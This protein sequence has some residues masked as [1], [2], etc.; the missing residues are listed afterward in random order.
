MKL[1]RQL[2][3]TNHFLQKKQ[4]KSSSNTSTADVHMNF[5]KIESMSAIQENEQVS[6]KKRDDD[7]Y[8]ELAHVE[9]NVRQIENKQSESKEW[10]LRFI[11]I[12]MTVLMVAVVILTI[13]RM[14]NDGFA[15]KFQQKKNE[16]FICIFLHN[17]I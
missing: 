7:I 9:R 2:K 6:G 10:H 17:I 15:E 8:Q 4:P 3:T 12:M 13:S 16:M 5:K 1:R 14:F 11:M